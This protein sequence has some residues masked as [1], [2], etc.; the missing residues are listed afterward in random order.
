M[1]DGDITAVRINATG[2][3]A[4]IDIAGLSTGGVYALGMGANNEPDN[5]KVVFNVT[6]Q[7]YNA[8]CELTTMQ[9]TVYGT[10]YKRKIYPNDAQADES[11]DGDTLSVTVALSDW[12]YSA[13]TLTV[14]ISAGFYTQGG[15]PNNSTSSLPVTNNSGEAYPRVIGNW[16]Y[17]GWSR[18]TGTSLT[19]RAVAFHRS[20]RN[21]VPVQA[22]KFTATDEH[23]HS[24]STIVTTPT[25]DSNMPDALPVIEYIG[26]LS[27]ASLTDG[28]LMTCNFLAYP[29]YGDADS[30]LNTGDGVNT[31]PTPLYA[32]QYHLLDKSNT[33]G[34]TVAVVDSVSGNDG[35]GVCIDY[36]SFDPESPPNAYLTIA[37]A[38]SGIAA[39]NNTNHSRNDPGAGILYLKEGSYTFT[40]GTVSTAGKASAVTWTTL[41]K[42]PGT[43]TANVIIASADGTK[44][45]GEKLK[46]QDVTITSGTS[47][48]FSLMDYLWMDQCDIHP[49]LTTGGVFYAN[50]IHY[51]THNNLWNCYELSPYST[52]NYSR[53]LVRGNK[54]QESFDKAIKA[55]TVLGNDMETGLS[56]SSNYTGQTCPAFHNVVLAYNKLIH[57]ADN[58]IFDFPG[59][60]E[61][62]GY[63]V[64]Q[65]IMETQNGATPATEFASG[66]AL[67]TVSVNN[68]L[69][70]HNTIVGER[71]NYAFN[72]WN[73]NDVGPAY[74][75]H[76]HLQGNIFDDV[77]VVTDIHPH[78]GTPD[79]DRYGNH[80]IIHGAGL[81]SNI[82]LNRVG[83]AGY[84]L[85][86]GGLYFKRDDPLNPYFTD[87][88]SG[89]GGEG[90]NG[91][92]TLEALSPAINMV[93]SGFAVLP[94][95]IVG[96]TR[97]NDG[98]GAI[99]AYEYGPSELSAMRSQ[100]SFFRRN[101]HNIWNLY[102]S[103]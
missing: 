50:T 9:R 88:Q 85:K 33:Y 89:G 54:T 43:I 5:A 2:W 80:S 21:G 76:W 3:Y 72:D 25:I 90:G 102:N 66:T 95:D 12:I 41:T 58:V 8:S 20:A 49:S 91:T 87:D 37:A 68:V 23:S 51:F 29:I 36:G 96:N 35:T 75:L 52:G 86:F 56:I 55:H 27:T 1:A 57:N 24:V 77:N 103:R 7:G 38:A 63:A 39:Y 13:D 44:Q 59:A 60:E 92:Y 6:S 82:I 16:S 93:A 84:E 83:A 28:D 97:R 100:Y 67:G 70:W 34:V 101:I 62:H 65:N 61:L 98:T 74:R 53:A 32:P 40:A 11:E 45:I 73:L 78:G 42:F 15:T 48:T 17:P 47:S 46:V 14:D 10:N 69:I 81:I 18:V 71:C 94:Y 64:V 31:M 19:L 99:G 30:V 79:D 26:T 22:I 4:E